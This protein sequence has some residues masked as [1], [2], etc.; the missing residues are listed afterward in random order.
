MWQAIIQAFLNGLQSMYINDY[1]HKQSIGDWNMQNNYNENMYNQYNSPVARAKQLSDAGLSD[2]AIGAALSGFNGSGTQIASAPMNP[3]NTSGILA[4]VFGALNNTMLSNSET[5]LNNSNRRLNFVELAKRA[6]EVGINFYNLKL[7]KKTLPAL[8][9]K[10][11]LENDVLRGNIQNLIADYNLKNSQRRSTELDTQLKEID[12]YI[13]EGTK[14]TQI[15]EIENRVKLQQQQFGLNDMQVKNI[16]ANIVYI[17]AQTDVINETKNV[18]KKE[19]LEAEFYSNF[20]SKY[21]IPFND[22][23]DAILKGVNL[24]GS[25]FKIFGI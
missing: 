14:N 22:A 6:T 4:D 9:D 2:A 24:I 7:L 8:C 25:L 5:R 17:K 15:E 20:L 11:T 1:Q 21:G 23:K 12:R 13:K 19:A 10:P 16:T 18:R 3:T